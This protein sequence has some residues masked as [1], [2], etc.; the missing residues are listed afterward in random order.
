MMSL[1]EMDRSVRTSTHR[2]RRATT[3]AAEDAAVAP[4]LDELGPCLARGQD[5]V[6]DGRVVRFIAGLLGAT[7]A[8]VTDELLPRLRRRDKESWAYLIGPFAHLY[9]ADL[10]R[11]L[12][13]HSPFKGH[14]VVCVHQPVEGP[15]EKLEMVGDAQAFHE[16]LLAGRKPKA[17][18]YSAIEAFHGGQILAVRTAPSKPRTPRPHE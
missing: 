10:L 4:F 5:H 17:Y 15:F 8:Y 9:G 16:A 14:A 2:A 1:H 6:D 12:T 7:A 13:S 3:E 11:R 18:A